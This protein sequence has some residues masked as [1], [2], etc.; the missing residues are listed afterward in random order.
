MPIYFFSISFQVHIVNND[1]TSSIW[2]QAA[3]EENTHALS[4]NMHNKTNVY[5]H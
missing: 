3:W 1:E 5:N 2:E 4:E